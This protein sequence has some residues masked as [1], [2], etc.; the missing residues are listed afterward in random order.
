MIEKQINK[1]P[2]PTHLEK[3]GD[4]AEKQMAHYLKRAYQ[5]NKDIHVINDL[6]LVLGDDAAQIDHLVIHRFGFIIVI[7]LFIRRYSLPSG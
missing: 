5:K 1:K 3:A 2:A 7:S 6:R 4:E